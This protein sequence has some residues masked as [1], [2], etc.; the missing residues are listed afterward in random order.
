MSLEQFKDR[1]VGT[2]NYVTLELDRT[3][4]TGWGQFKQVVKR[5]FQP[6]LFVGLGVTFREMVNTLFRGKLHTTKY[7]FESYQSHHV[8]EPF[9]TCF[10]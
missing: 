1:N 9:M 10:V 3:A 6:E 5:T 4:T 2:Q 8:T 7:P